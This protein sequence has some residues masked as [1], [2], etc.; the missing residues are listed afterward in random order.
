M[1][2]F[3][4]LGQGGSGNDEMHGG[5]GGDELKGNSGN[6]LIYGG[7]GDDFLY[8]DYQDYDFSICDYYLMGD[9][10]TGGLTQFMVVTAM[11][12]LLGVWALM[13][14]LEGRAQIYS[15]LRGIMTLEI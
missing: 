3:K 8:G 12:S 2:E 11:I 7:G 6:D 10:H 4:S 9:Q 5:A 15:P 1:E 14:F 13:T